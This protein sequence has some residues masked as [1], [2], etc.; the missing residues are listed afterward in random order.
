MLSQI[1]DDFATGV[2]I[3]N[4]NSEIVFYNKAQGRI[5]NIEPE[6]ALGKTLLDLYKVGENT[7]HPAL[8]SIFS[9]KPLSNY[10][11]YYHTHQGKLVNSIQN[12]FPIMREGA[13]VGSIAFIS[14]YGQALDNFEAF[15]ASYKPVALKKRASKPLGLEDVITED[16]A[17]LANLDIILNSADSLSP[18]MLHGEPGTGKDMFARILHNISDRKDA[19]FLAI[20]CSSFPESLLDGV[21]FGT[22]EGAFTGAKGKPGLF[23]LADGGTLFLDGIHSMPSSLQGKL[24]RAIEEQKIRRVGGTEEREVSLKVLS[25]TTV[26][27]REAVSEGSFRPELM[28]KLGVVLISIPPLRERPVDIPLLTAS[29]IR[30]LNS[31]LNRQVESVATDVN[32]A[33][34][35]YLWPGNV[36]EL[37]YTLES[38]ISQL[39]QEEKVLRLSHFNSSLFAD[40]LRGASVPVAEAE[41]GKA[42]KYEPVRT[43]ILL[44]R[45]AEVERIAAA[46][47]AAG[48]NAAKAARSLKISP[49]LMNYKLKKFCLKK[50]ITVHVE[51]VFN[52]MGPQKRQSGDGNGTSQ[53]GH[54]L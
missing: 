5:D 49:Q 13:L 38:A 4:V 10:P 50:K 22:E 53:T 30:A 37:Y 43:G 40:V 2:T 51:R 20:N 23:E 17:M 3:I 47:E 8:L 12:I 42:P 1:F 9:C 54:G 46:L 34:Q 25:A 33:I 15:Q 32:D 41:T 31:R 26:N 29:F 28:L 36:Q 21:L 19:P 6:H 27:P 24:L 48:G 14:E 45:A 16:K 52:P 35:G 44:H 18:V 11:C 7:T 39:P